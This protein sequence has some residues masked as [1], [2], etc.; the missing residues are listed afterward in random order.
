[1]CVCV[2]VCVCVCARTRVCACVVRTRVCPFVRLNIVSC[3]RVCT[4]VRAYV[5]T[6]CAVTRKGYF[7]D[8]QKNS[9][10]QLLMEMAKVNKKLKTAKPI[11]ICNK[12]LLTANVYYL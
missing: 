5:I 12:I 7:Y 2:C 8:K 11:R 10:M 6:E 4:Y 3:E 9:R 1:M